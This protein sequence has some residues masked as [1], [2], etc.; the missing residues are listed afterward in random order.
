VTQIESFTKGDQILTTKLRNM[1][2]DAFADPV[3]AQQ[4]P[5]SKGDLNFLGKIFE[6]LTAP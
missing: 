5:Y 6:N 4:M 3:T 1:V 2:K